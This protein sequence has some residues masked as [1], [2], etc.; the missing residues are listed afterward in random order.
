MG[1][2]RPDA[3]VARSV[4]MSGVLVFGATS[5][6]GS[7]FVAHPP[8]GVAIAAAGR[9]SPDRI[10]IPPT[11]FDAVDL[12]DAKAVETVVAESPELVVVN[13]AARTDVDGVERERPAVA[14]AD[15]TLS[16]AYRVNALAP[17][18]MARGARANGKFL[19]T[20]STDFIFD[21][22]RGPYAEAAPPDPLGPR[23]S[24][25]G[26]TKGEGERR[27]RATLP[28][29]AVVRI[30]YPYRPPFGGK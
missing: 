30:S 15:P 24:W 14:S 27:V 2:R 19:I 7:H 9:R 3:S 16:N 28:Q 1:P 26:W 4:T 18:A 25:Y 22:H 6:V 17:E 10:G 21:G 23:V 11:R 29:A 20:I 13:F 8:A 5:L 12:H